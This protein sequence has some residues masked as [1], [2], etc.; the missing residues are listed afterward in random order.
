MPADA[1]TDENFR[2]YLLGA[3]DGTPKTPEWASGDLRH[4]G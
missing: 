2:D 4:A 3:Y 1:T